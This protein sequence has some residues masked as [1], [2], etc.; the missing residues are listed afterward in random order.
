MLEWDR[1]TTIDLMDAVRA[2][3]DYRELITGVLTRFGATESTVARATAE[4]DSL[5]SVVR[6]SEPEADLEPKKTRPPSLGE[7]VLAQV[8]AATTDAVLASRSVTAAEHAR[9]F[10][11]VAINLY[12]ASYV[13]GDTGAAY[14]SYRQWL[15]LRN[16][17]GEPGVLWHEVYR[18]QWPAWKAHLRKSCD[19]EATL[20]VVRVNGASA[21]SIGW[22]VE[23]IAEEAHLHGVRMDSSFVSWLSGH[24]EVSQSFLQRAAARRRFSAAVNLAQHASLRSSREGLPR[25]TWAEL[26]PYPPVAWLG[27]WLNAANAVPTSRIASIV[28]QAYDTLTPFGP[29]RPHGASKRPGSSPLYLDRHLFPGNRGPLADFLAL[30]PTRRLD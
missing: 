19:S 16:L 29:V 28:A 5:A 18:W 7:I 8:Q 1:G 25:A 10:S 27:H 21:D 3:V 11:L 17:G 24:E 9:I 22:L 20:E 6:A 14:R 4:L 12:L 13:L 2:G 26:G 15:A 30:R 23:R